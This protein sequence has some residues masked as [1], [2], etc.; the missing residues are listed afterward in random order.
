LKVFC[1]TFY[2]ES[3]FFKKRRSHVQMTLNILKLIFE[4]FAER[5]ETLQRKNQNKDFQLVL[6]I[7][8]NPAQNFAQRVKVI[9]SCPI[10]VE[11]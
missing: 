1:I 4:N 9:A 6:K 3:P 2:S 8:F 10:G 5:Y 11:Q 7:L